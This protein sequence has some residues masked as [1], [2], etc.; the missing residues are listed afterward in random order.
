M[1]K[2]I[3]Q[4][5]LFRPKNFDRTEPFGRKK[6]CIENCCDNNCGKFSAAKK[7]IVLCIWNVLQ[8]PQAGGKSL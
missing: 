4:S 5:E 6:N 7:L 2:N 3:F 8:G 1:P